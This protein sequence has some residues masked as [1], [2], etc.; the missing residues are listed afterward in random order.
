MNNILC[1]VPHYLNHCFSLLA[2][3]TNLVLPLLKH[4]RLNRKEKHLLRDLISQLIYFLYLIGEDL[5]L[6]MVQKTENK[7]K[8]KLTIINGGKND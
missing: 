5:D 3:M 8:L 1:N 4:R 7:A 6:E 2:A